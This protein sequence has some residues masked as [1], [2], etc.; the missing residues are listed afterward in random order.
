M[1]VGFDEYVG[2]DLYPIIPTLFLDPKMPVRFLK[3]VMISLEDVMSI[4]EV[5]IE[6]IEKGNGDALKNAL[7]NLFDILGEPSGET[8]RMLMDEAIFSEKQEAIE[9]FNDLQAYFKKPAP[10][11]EY[12]E[13]DEDGLNKEEALLEV[14]DEVA[15]DIKQLRFNC[16]DVDELVSFLTSGLKKYGIVSMDVEKVQDSLAQKLSSMTVEQRQVYM[17]SFTNQDDLNE[18]NANDQLFMILGPVN[19]IVEGDFTQ[20][21]HICFKYGGCRMFYCNCYES[22]WL[23]PEDETRPY[24]PNV[25]LWF[26]GICEECGREVEKRCYAVRRPLPQGGWRGTYCSWKCLYDSG[27][28]DDV[29]TQKL[30]KMSE[31]RLMEDRILDREERNVDEWL[32]EEIEKNEKGYVYHLPIIK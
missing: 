8:F 20:Q 22:D 12:I 23:N 9:F 1:E 29:L 4:E 6:V 27:N 18:L 24:Y 11:P 31:K 10:R 17:K 5:A 14:A 26:T 3:F 15:N 16:E 25:P 2:P 7:K 13:V 32:K 19:P 28:V 21:D 30:C